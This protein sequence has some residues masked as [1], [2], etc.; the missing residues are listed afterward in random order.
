MSEIVEMQDVDP[1]S[2]AKVI[3]EGGRPKIKVGDRE[4]ALISIEDLEF[5]EE[6]E[7][8]LDLLDALES[9]REACEDKR[10]IPWDDLLRDLKQSRDTHGL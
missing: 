3:E 8:K 9:L 2:F 1:A 10:I 4:C 6:I 7:N 5:L